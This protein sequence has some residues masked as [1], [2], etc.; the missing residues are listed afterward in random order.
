MM[1]STMPI[2]T[3]PSSAITTGV[4]ERQHRAQFGPD[5][6]RPYSMVV[7]SLFVSAQGRHVCL[8]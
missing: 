6:F 8:S 2:V 1:V 4:G 5:H 3:Q 7:M